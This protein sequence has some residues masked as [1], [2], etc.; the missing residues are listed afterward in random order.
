MATWLIGH[1]TV[2]DSAKWQE[3]VGQVGATVAEAGGEVMFRGRLQEQVCGEAPGQL[4][5][6]IRFADQ[7][8]LRRWHD[9]AAYQRLISIRQAAA[10]VVLSAYED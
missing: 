8:S 9:S 5:V 4:V 3:Y 6:A 10:D 2:R 1:M 7:A